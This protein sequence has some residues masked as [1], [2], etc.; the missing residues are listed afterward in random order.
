MV[1]ISNHSYCS[2][3]TFGGFFFSPSSPQHSVLKMMFVL[4]KVSHVN[5]I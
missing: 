3:G 1:L 5:E 4:L 2:A